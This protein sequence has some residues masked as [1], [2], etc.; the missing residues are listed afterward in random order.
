MEA[1]KTEATGDRPLPTS[2][3]HGID[4]ASQRVDELDAACLR[5]ALE[6]APCVAVDLGCGSGFQ[7]LRLALLGCRT[8]LVDRIDPHPLVSVACGGLPLRHLQADLAQLRPDQM[9]DGVGIATSQ[10][11]LHYL[12]F[13]EALNFL[14]TVS[15]RIFLSASGLESE[16]G[17]GYPAMGEPLHR[18]F[19]RLDPEI[20]RRHQILVPVCLYAER[21]MS[22]ILVIS[23]FE[24]LVCFRSP[25]GNVKAIGEVPAQRP[26]AV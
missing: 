17:S 8:L 26:G 14:K 1:G 2:G 21:D 7:G 6:R 20:G 11:F 24:V 23:G 13:D 10:R 9:P 5:F 12:R 18:R 16:L 22:R 3:R 4:V 19:A 15:G 25:F